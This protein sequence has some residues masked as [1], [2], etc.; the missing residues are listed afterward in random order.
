MEKK[1]VGYVSVDSGQIMIV[2]PAYLSKYVDNDF[3]YETGVKKGNKKYVLWQ[4]ID[5]KNITWD[6]PIKKEGGKTMNDLVEE[7]WEEFN[8]YPDKGDFSY[9]G[10][11]SVTVSEKV[12]EITAT[13][14]ATAVVSSSGYGDGNYPVTAF[15]KDGRVVKLEI[16]FK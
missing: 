4:K 6:T 7:G 9:S 3:R 15:I 2:D 16:D 12:G 1:L 5:G 14:S 13:G 11:S 8:D 10:V